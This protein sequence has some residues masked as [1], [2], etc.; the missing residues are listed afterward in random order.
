MRKIDFTQLE[1]IREFS[2]NYSLYKEHV[3]LPKEVH[4][5]IKKV[6]QVEEY[7]IINK[8]E[9]ES[10]IVSIIIKFMESLV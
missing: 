1:D 4:L 3:S 8:R 6:H 2:Q 7:Q 10:R 9:A 5:K